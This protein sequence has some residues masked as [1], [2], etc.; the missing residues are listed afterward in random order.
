MTVRF[1]NFSKKD[2]FKKVNLHIHS[3]FSDGKMNFEE[4]IN[5]AKALN[6][7]CF[8]ITDHNTVEGYKNISDIPNSMVK[9]VEFDCYMDLNFPHILGYGI[10]VESE[11]LLKI[12]TKFKKGK[13]QLIKR[14]LSS[15]NPKKVIEAI[16]KAGGIAV[17]AHP[18]CYWCLNLEKFVSKLKKIGLDGIEAYYPYDRATRVF[19]FHRE[20]KVLEIAEKYNLIKTGGK[21][22]H[23][24]LTGEDYN[25]NLQ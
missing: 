7:E 13:L 15:R 18:C 25:G 10:D 23:G 20:E 12:T 8:S 1:K 5:E 17:L 3:S 22:T 14:I 21:D 4:L 19:T 11:D 6:L 24:I 16:H 2:F 9:G